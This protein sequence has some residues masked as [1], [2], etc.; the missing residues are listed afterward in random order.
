MEEYKAKL[1]IGSIL[2]DTGKLLYRYN[3]MRN[4]STSGYDFL[5]NIIDNKDILDCVRYHHSAALKNADIKDDALCYITYIADNI[6]AFSDR[7]KNENGEGGFVRDISC[8]SVFNILNG[9][10]HSAAYPPIM[11]TEKN[12]INYPSQADKKYSEEFYG[13]VVDGL[14]DS[15]RGIEYSAEYINSLCEVFEAYTSFIPS[16]TNSGELRDI[17]LYDHVKLTAALALCIFDYLKSEHIVEFRKELY[18]N[19]EAFYDKKAFLLY[20]ADISGI[21]NFIYNIGSKSALKGLRARSFWLEL[22]VESAVDD[23]LDRLSLARCNVM[24]VGG[25]HTYLLLPNTENVRSEIARFEKEL[26]LWLID[27]FGAELYIGGGY[28]ECSANS[29]RNKPDGSYGNIFT[30]VSRKISSAKV[31]RYTAQDMIKLNTPIPESDKG[32]ECVICRRSD[33]LVKYK[34]DCC[35]VCRSLIALSDS[36]I[37][38]NSFFTV[39]TKK[40]EA[41]DSVILPFGRYLTADNENQLTT[42]MGNDSTYLRSY[43]KNK[44]YTGKRLASR[45][46]VG[47][48][49]KEKDFAQFIEKCQGIKRLGVFRADIDNLGQSFVNGFSSEYNTISRTSELSS[50]LS[51]FFKHDIN[52]ILNEPKFKLYHDLADDREITIVYSGGDDV[53]AVGSWEDII[54]FAVD[55]RESFKKFSLG[56]LSISGGIGIFPEKYPIYEMASATGDLEDISKKMKDQNGNSVKDS[57]TLFDESGCYRW[58]TFTEIVVGEKLKTLRDFLDDNKEKGKA[59][60]YNMLSLIREKD[61]G[62]RLNLARFAYLISRISPE[63]KDDVEMSERFSNFRRKIYGW[64]NNDEDR[65]Q[66]V[67]AIYLYVYSIRDSERNEE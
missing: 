25:G 33:R 43:V 18:E 48:Y 36:I 3:D 30:E 56:T 26:N 17:S 58:D 65:R 8:E 41:G 54:G 22:A 2:H 15:L 23:L 46:W 67:T 44:M 37:G 34:E 51:L 7:R 29:L 52:T 32:R 60:L 10:K 64:I 63:N 24:Y 47:D 4:H 21:Q 66:L 45:I 1:A 39:L 11:L 38:D 5:K 14:K 59:M 61:D 53:F 13:R 40:P 50:K 49:C 28:S 20:S 27:N 35:E 42:R 62:S 55:L 16:S 12:E 57:I 31:N 6:A 9:G 19:S